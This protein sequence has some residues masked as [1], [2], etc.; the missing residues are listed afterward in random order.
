M[1]QCS[2]CSSS[3]S[4]AAAADGAA[5]LLLRQHGPACEQVWASPARPG[6]ARLHCTALLLLQRCAA[7]RQH[8]SACEQ[9]LISSGRARPRLRAA[10]EQLWA[11]P[12]RRGT[13]GTA[14]DSSC[15]SAAASEQPPSSSGPAWP[16]P[17]LILLAQQRRARSR[18]ERELSQAIHRRSSQFLVAQMQFLLLRRV[19]VAQV[20]FRLLRLVT[21]TFFNGLVKVAQ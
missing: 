17:L 16:G 14:L 12:A 2:C 11:S 9:P 4:T 13:G 1:L 6:A 15:C 20:K 21:P 7:L 8:G 19:S 10:C 18:G 3:S 5:V